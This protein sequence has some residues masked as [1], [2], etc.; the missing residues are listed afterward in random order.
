[1]DLEYFFWQIKILKL[2][3]ESSSIK[4]Y[5]KKEENQGLSI[6]SFFILLPFLH[7]KLQILTKFIILA[8]ILSSSNRDFVGSEILSLLQ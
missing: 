6:Y 3:S 8:V 5:I 1:M 4:M 7:G 2:T